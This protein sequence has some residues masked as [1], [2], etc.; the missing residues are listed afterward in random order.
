M[1]FVQIFFLMHIWITF[2]FVCF[3]AFAISHKSYISFSASCSNF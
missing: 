1:N 2:I 3:I